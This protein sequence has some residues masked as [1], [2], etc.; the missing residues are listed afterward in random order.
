MSD[1]VPKRWV[2]GDGLRLAVWEQGEPGAPTVVLVHGYPDTHAV[3]RDVAAELADRFHVVT[4]DVRGAGESDVPADREGYDLSHLVADLSSVADATSPDRPIH[5][6]GHD[7]GSIQAWEAVTTD[8]LTGRI[9]SFTSIS[10]PSLDH[11]AEWV[12][13]RRRG[14]HRD[15]RALAAQGLRSWYVAVFQLPGLAPLAWR[16][17]A[18]SA[19]RRGL[20]RAEG[21]DVE[22]HPAPTLA[23]DGANG[24]E[25]YRRNVPHRMRAPSTR[26]TDVPVQLIVPLGDR[27]VTPALLADVGHHCADLT[28]REVSGGHWVPVSR[29]TDVAHRIAEHIERVNTT[30]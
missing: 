14:E 1:A 19:L 8:L 9:A 12:R 13:V 21:I 6:V 30:S 7:W 20:R 4:Y 27:F 3:W 2:E 16:T 23:R 10:G 29:P 15:L 5:L 22:H 25:L 11:V 24:V 18:P 17:V 28:R 26:I